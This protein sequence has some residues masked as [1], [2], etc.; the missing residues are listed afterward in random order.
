M[1][2][3]NENQ[4]L[5]EL[6]IKLPKLNVSIT[7]KVHGLNTALVDLLWDTLPYRS[8]QT[9]ALVTGDQYHLVPSEPLIYTS[10]EHKITDRAEEPDGTVFLSK[11]QHLAIKYG[12]VTEHHPAALCG[13]VVPEDLEKLRWL[14]KEVWKSQ[15]ET[16]SQLRSFSGM[17]Q[18]M[19][20]ALEVYHFDFSELVRR[21]R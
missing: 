17:L 4:V 1:E 15:I 21:K 10:T 12:R 11:F 2:Q 16:K 3:H 8:L 14:G 19:S 18:T 7:V 20:L 13:N 9:H 6:R 5:R